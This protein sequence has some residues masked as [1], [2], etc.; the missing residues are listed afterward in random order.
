MN[1]VV[2]NPVSSNEIIF[3]TNKSFIQSEN[4]RKDKDKNQDQKINNILESRKEFTKDS[5]KSKRGKEDLHSF[6]RGLENEKL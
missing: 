6:E 3:V 1:S 4:T 5:N 2:E